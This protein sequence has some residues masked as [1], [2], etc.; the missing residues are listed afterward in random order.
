MFLRRIKQ[1]KISSLMLIA[2]YKVARVLVLYI[3]K[4][5]LKFSLYSNVTQRAKKANLK[6]V[7]IFNFVLSPQRCLI[8]DADKILN[9][10]I[11]LFDRYYAINGWLKDPISGK[12]WPS[13]VFFA[14]SKTKLD[15]YGDVK[16]V[17]ELNKLNHLVVISTAYYYTKDNKYIDYIKHNLEHWRSVVKYE[18]SVANKII[19]DVAFRCINLIFV[20]VLCYDS[21]T[22]SKEIYPTIHE[23]LILSERQMRNFCT[24][25]WFKTG[26][27]A[28]HVIGEMVGLIIT[29]RWLNLTENKT[30]KNRRIIQKEYSW[31]FETLNKLVTS[32]GVYLENSANYT[33]LV[34]EF[35]IALDIFDDIWGCGNKQLRENYLFP[36]L[37]YLSSLSYH[38]MLPNFGDNDAATVLISFKKNFSD[39]NPLLEY[40]N[41]LN[42]NADYKVDLS[43]YSK[44]GHFLWKSDNSLDLYLFIRFGNWSVFKQGAASHSHCDLLSVLLYAKGFPLFVDKG[45]YYYNQSTNIRKE[46]ILTYSHNTISI[47]NCEQANYNKGWYNYPKSE[48]LKPETNNCI[49]TGYVEY[50]SIRHTRNIFLDNNILTIIDVLDGVS[51]LHQATLNY[52]LHESIIPSIKCD[53]TIMLSTPSEPLAIMIVNGANMSIVD[54]EY[55]PHYA[56]KCPTHAVRGGI[57]KKTITTKIIFFE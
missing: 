9:G 3:E 27:G 1:Y 16:Y 39:I 31:L 45:C 43:M 33:R 28:N 42:K 32:D 52:I 53:D 24:P 7:G 4:C 5:R 20:S 22:F 18:R 51:N 57:T 56:T 48:I 6:A 23:I 2:T 38:G 30:R 47:L 11:Y 29:Q 10:N 37:N 12:D 21:D 44:V 55:Y 35:L 17:L 14:N 36:I 49:F 41:L 34:S 13:K 46:C 26:N 54:T 8:N 40:Y 15:G 19:M 25:R 50:N